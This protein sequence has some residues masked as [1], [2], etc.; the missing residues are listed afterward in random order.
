[1]KGTKLTPNAVEP[2]TFEEH[3]RGMQRGGATTQPTE[4][5]P[6]PATRPLMTLPEPPLPGNER[7]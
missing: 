1:M 3:M 6:P 5:P 4:T 7:H 2:G